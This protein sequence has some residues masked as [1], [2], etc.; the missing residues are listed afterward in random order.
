MSTVLKPSRARARRW[1]IGLLG[2]SSIITLMCAGM[3]LKVRNAA[4]SMKST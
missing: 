1:V 3:V 2:C 4:Q